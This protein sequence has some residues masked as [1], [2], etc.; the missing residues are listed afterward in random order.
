MPII[1]L[2][3]LARITCLFTCPQ[4]SGREGTEHL[5]T[6]CCPPPGSP[7]M[8]T[9]VGVAP[10]DRSRVYFT[11]GPRKSFQ[12]APFGSRMLKNKRDNLHVALQ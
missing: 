1:R 2:L 6:I 4:R 7:E 9:R 11:A 8:K 12:E 10:G 5:A 3:Y